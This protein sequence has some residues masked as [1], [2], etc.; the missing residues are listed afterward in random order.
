MRCPSWR[1]SSPSFTRAPVALVYLGVAETALPPAALDG[2]G[3]L[4]AKDED[5][6]V[7]GIVFESTVWPDRA[8]AGHVLL[9][10]VFG[11]ARDPAAVVAR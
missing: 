8:P 4:V 10:C 3:L 2:F 11:G 6:R 7:L 1:R 9:R 5:L